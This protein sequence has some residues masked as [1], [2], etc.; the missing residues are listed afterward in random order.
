MENEII[1]KEITVEEKQQV[2]NLMSEVINHLERPEFYC[3][4]NPEKEL[5]KMFDANY[6]Y[7]LGAYDNQKLVGIAQLYIEQKE[8][9]YYINIADLNR[10][11]VGNFGTALVL[12][13]YRN[14]GIMQNLIKLQKRKST[15]STLGLYVGN[16]PP[17]KHTK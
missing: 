1:Y 15:K 16:C 14:R 11:Q 2:L 10:F 3:V 17:R 8:L 13:E 6:V 4:G 5:Q 9:E 7:N 12:K